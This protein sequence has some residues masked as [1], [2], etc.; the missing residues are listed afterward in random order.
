MNTVVRVLAAITTTGDINLYNVGALTLASFD[1]LSVVQITGSVNGN[2]GVDDLTIRTASPLTIDIPVNDFAGGHI[3]QAAEGLAATDNLTINAAITASNGSGSSYGNILLVAGHDL[4]HN[5]GLISAANA[6]NVSLS[7]GEDYHGGSQQGGNASGNV[8]MAN[9]QIIASGSGNISVEATGS[10]ALSILTTSGGDVSVSADDDDFNLQDGTGTITDNLATEAPNI[11]GHLGTF[12]AA[13]GIGATDDIGTCLAT[14]DADNDGLNGATLITEQCGALD[15]YRLSQSRVGGSGRIELVTVAGTLTIVAGQQGVSAAGSGNVRLFAD[16]GNGSDLIINDSINSDPS[17]GYAWQKTSTNESGWDSPVRVFDR[18]A[19]FPPDLYMPL[20]LLRQGAFTGT[21][22]TFQVDTLVQDLMESNLLESKPLTYQVAVTSG[23]FGS[24]HDAS[25]FT[26]SGDAF[27]TGQT[28]TAA[29]GL[30]EFAQLV[31]RGVTVENLGDGL[32]LL[33]VR[34]RYA[35][36]KTGWTAVI[37]GADIRPMASVGQLIILGLGPKEADGSSTDTYQGI[38]ATP[39]ALITVTTSNGTVMDEDLDRYL[40]GVQVRTDAEGN[41]TFHVPR[42]TF[43]GRREPAMPRVTGRGCILTARGWP[44]SPPG[45]LGAGRTARRL[46]PTRWPRRA[47]S[48]SIHRVRPRRSAT[49]ASCRPRRI[50]PRP[51]SAGPRPS[52]QTISAGVATTS[53]V[54]SIPRGTPR[55]RFRSKP[56]LATRINW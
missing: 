41:F 13:T 22:A 52:W 46:R 45:R 55:R 44:R 38:E 40:Q 4:F 16:G 28:A 17:T 56:R 25:E 35:G 30:A 51:A 5:L 26:V 33:Q 43:G 1:G 9:G 31:F 11:I 37:N 36:D 10:I 3:T 34:M 20:S 8:S 27:V 47:A 15:V 54:T 29:T 7:A 24:V 23:D 48:T 50:R 2:L 49:W 12:R 42:S 32:G 6:G 53:A 39:N 19:D 21:S 18:G 14:L